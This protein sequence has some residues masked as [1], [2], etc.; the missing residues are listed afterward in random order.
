MNKARVTCFGD[1]RKDYQT[2]EMVVAGD[3]T[4]HH[5]DVRDQHFVG[6]RLLWVG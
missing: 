3:S 5:A 2:S 1:K 4:G 6:A